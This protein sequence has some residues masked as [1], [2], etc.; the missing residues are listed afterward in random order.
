[1]L[2]NQL[3][4]T[5]LFVGA[6][7]TSAAAASQKARWKH[8]SDF[9]ARASEEPGEAASSVPTRRGRPD[10]FVSYTP[11]EVTRGIRHWTGKC[12]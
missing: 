6:S 11:V 8:A 7:M 9:Y 4:L 1:M 10:C 3:F 2:R 5:A 12:R